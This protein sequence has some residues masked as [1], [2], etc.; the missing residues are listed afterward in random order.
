VKK[1]FRRRCWRFSNLRSLE[2]K[3]LAAAKRPIGK[4]RDDKCLVRSRSGVTGVALEWHQLRYLILEARRPMR[5]SASLKLDT[6][7]CPSSLESPVGS[8]RQ[9]CPKN[10]NVGAGLGLVRIPDPPGRRSVGG[11]KPSFSPPPFLR[12]RSGSCS[13]HASKTYS[14]SQLNR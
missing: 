1:L 8:A 10:R 2:L 4:G 14:N 11:R 12:L 13:T 9:L 7:H 3:S 5:E 6:S